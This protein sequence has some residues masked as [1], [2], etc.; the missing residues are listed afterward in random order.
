MPFRKCLVFLLLCNAT[1]FAYADLQPDLDWKLD[2]EIIRDAASI[3]IS[4]DAITTV[5]LCSWDT[6]ESLPRNICR[7]PLKALVITIR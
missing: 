2:G 1:S 3:E 4:K 7:Y 6:E 5:D